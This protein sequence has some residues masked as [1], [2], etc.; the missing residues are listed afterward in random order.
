MH[1]QGWG[2]TAIIPGSG[3]LPDDF[4]DA[5][6]RVFDL[7]D[8]EYAY[9]REDIAI[10]IEPFFGTM[11]VCPAGASDAAGD[12]ARDV[13]RQHGHAAARA[14]ARRSTCPSRSTARCSPA[15]TPT[16]PRATARSASPASRRRCRG[17]ALHAR[18]GP[19][20]PRAAVPHARRR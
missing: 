4:P 15:A 5:Y 1:T 9:L 8:G 6:L 18:E 10:P 14:R 7:T 12:A 16:P 19:H 2:W 17:A 20:D 11:G 13:R 3:L